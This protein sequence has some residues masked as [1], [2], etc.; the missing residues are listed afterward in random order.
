LGQNAG[1][2]DAPPP[3]STFCWLAEK[4]TKVFTLPLGVPEMISVEGGV[5][6]VVPTTGWHVTLHVFSVPPRPASLEQVGVTVKITLP[7]VQPPVTWPWQFVAPY[8]QSL[9]QMSICVP[10][11]PQL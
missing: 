10:H 6:Q 3:T 9:W 7:G 8:S 2:I 4:F 11:K 5:S 1:S